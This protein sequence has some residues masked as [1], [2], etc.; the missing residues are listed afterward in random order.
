MASASR[1]WRLVQVDGV[2]ELRSNELLEARVFFQER[3]GV[4][5]SQTELTDLQIQHELMAIYQGNAST[6][7]SDRYLAEQCLRCFVS[8]QIV[9]VCSRLA[10]KYVK[11]GVRREDLLHLVLGD[12]ARQFSAEQFASSA[13]RSL[14]TEIL[15]TFDP[16]RAGLNTWV[17]RQ[18]RHHRELNILLREHGVYLI[19]DWAILNDTRPEQLERILSQFYMLATPEIREAGLLLEAYHAIYRE[20]RWQQRQSG[21]IRGREECP[22]PTAE[23]L[24]RI[25]QQ[26]K[27]AGNLSLSNKS[28]LSRLQAI[29]TQLRHYRVYVRSGALP[30]KLRVEDTILEREEIQ[31]SEED[32]PSEQA[33]FLTFYREQFLGCLDQAIELAVNDRLTYLRRK[34]PKTA[35]QFLTAL[36]LFHC[37]GQAM[38]KIAPQIGLT[39]QYQVSRL[40][41]L[42]EFRA[43]VR[44]KML[45]L[46]KDRV[47][48]Q[49]KLYADPRYLLNLDHRIETALDE[50]IE[51]LIKEAAD[52]SA[53]G[54]RNCPLTGLFARRLCHQLNA[55]VN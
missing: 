38:G 9:Q 8:Q 26:I 18:V 29:A 27:E 47:F 45:K 1:Y 19:G 23:Q 13:Q 33:E 53:V 15:E 44:Q 16:S 10:N 51:Q 22:Q 3:F 55:V 41:K 32:A 49:A 43:S 34:A 7:S 11:H 52:Q 54:R 36:D 39:A 40:M 46:L 4:S 42:D 24:T 30:A 50:Q 14:A 12:V 6:R 21:A 20:D 31:A 28:I 37:Q 35:E 25:A 2:G 17:F 48:D 5:S